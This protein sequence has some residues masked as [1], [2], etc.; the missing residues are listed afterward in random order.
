MLTSAVIAAGYFCVL[1]LVWLGTLGVE[2][3]GQDL[4]LVLGPTFA[5][6]FGS[7]AK[8]AAIWFMI[9]NM[10][11]GTMQ[12]LAGASRTLAQLSE[13]GLAPRFLGLRS[14]RDVPWAA[15][16]LT[17]GTAI[18]FLLIGDPLWL[19]AASNFT[20]LIGI[21][22]PTL[23]VWLL[24]RNAPDAER[25]YR[26]PRGT[27]SLG[28]AAAAVWMVSTFLGFEQFGLPTVIAGL[29]MAH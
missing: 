2:P 17:A 25:P 1:P 6:V 24:R 22:L 13:D 18:L 19:I 4:A 7:L 26:A 12:P 20:Y 8:G 14:T 16:L 28:V 21:C 9:V 15:T 27:L 23:A 3:L 11:H 10:L 5:P 29:A